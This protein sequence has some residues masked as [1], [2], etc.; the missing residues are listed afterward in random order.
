[1]IFRYVQRFGLDTEKQYPYKGVDQACH[2]RYNTSDRTFLKEWTLLDHDENNA[3]YQ[4]TQLG[5]LGY[6][7]L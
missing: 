5:P 4:L 1:M 2:A 3:A 6:S 7:K